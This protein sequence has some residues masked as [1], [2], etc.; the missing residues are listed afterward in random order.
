MPVFPYCRNA[1]SYWSLSISA[2]YWRHFN[3]HHP[4]HS[5]V[6]TPNAFY[7]RSLASTEA[8]TRNTLAPLG[9]ACCTP[10][11]KEEKKITRDI[12][13]KKR[14]TSLWRKYSKVK[15]S[16]RGEGR[17]GIAHRHI[18]NSPES[19]PVFR[20]TLSPGEGGKWEAVGKT[21]T[22]LHLSPLSLM[23]SLIK[24]EQL[25]PYGDPPPLPRLVFSVPQV[26]PG[27][28]G[29]HANVWQLKKKNNFSVQLPNPSGGERESARG[30]KASR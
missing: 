13:K 12:E 10:G 22:I 28:V 6:A 24:D 7:R 27:F 3:S 15:E 25:C 19:S 29:L 5:T 14:K 30:R 23:W 11:V 16:R 18:K 8:N 20:N 21:K 26:S 1:K 2:S 17:G 4:Q 9:R